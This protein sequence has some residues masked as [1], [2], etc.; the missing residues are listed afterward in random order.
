VSIFMQKFSRGHVYSHNLPSLAQYYREYARF[1]DHWRAVL[2]LK[3]LEVDYEESVSD[4]EG[5]ARKVIDFL[6][7]KWDDACL[8][9]Q[10]TKR[11]VATASQWQVRQPIYKTSVER[12]RRYE[13]HIGPLIEGLKDLVG[14]GPASRP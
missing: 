11:A 1:A 14:N 3:M 10:H 13:A 6:G 7:L 12:W 2:P 8:S 4:T 5:Q 9:F